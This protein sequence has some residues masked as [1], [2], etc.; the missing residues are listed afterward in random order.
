MNGFRQSSWFPWLSALVLALWVPM[1]AAGC[2][3]L[4]AVLGALSLPEA[5]APPMAADH[6]CCKKTPAEPE[7]SSAM[8]CH[9]SHPSASGPDGKGCCIKDAGASHPG[10]AS[11]PVESALPAS[12]SLLPASGETLPVTARLPSSALPAD[13]GPPL[14]LAQRRLLI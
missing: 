2:C 3:K 7:A 1:L 9:P 8:P 14:W 11:T 4:S 6:A 13:D 5:E 12:A 10:L